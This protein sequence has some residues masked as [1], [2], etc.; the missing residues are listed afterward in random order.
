VFYGSILEDCGAAWRGKARLTRGG[1]DPARAEAEL[2]NQTMAGANPDDSDSP[3]SQMRPYHRARRCSQPAFDVKRITINKLGR[4]A[5][6]QHKD[7]AQDYG[8]AKRT[9]GAMMGPLA[10]HHLEDTS[11]PRRP[12]GLSL[13]ATFQRGREPEVG[14]HIER[15]VGARTIKWTISEIFKDHSSRQGT[16]VFTVKVDET[17]EGQPEMNETRE[18]PATIETGRDPQSS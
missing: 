4:L 18:T 16:V 1:R 15:T 11:A 8:R 2:V 5:L 12:S 13:R 14:E 17:E 9:C 10:S 3:D 6:K 7:F